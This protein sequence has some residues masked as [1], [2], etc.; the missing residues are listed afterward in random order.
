MKRVSVSLFGVSMYSRGHSELAY[1][2]PFSE[3]FLL[4]A[5]ILSLPPPLP[6][7]DGGGQN[8]LR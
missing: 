5:S 7:Q 8:Q 6:F 2:L 1:L 4:E 3:G